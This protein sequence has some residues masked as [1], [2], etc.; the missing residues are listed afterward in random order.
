MKDFNVNYQVKGGLFCKIKTRVSYY[1][2]FHA[3]QKVLKDHF[4][5]QNVHAICLVEIVLKKRIFA[6]EAKLF[7]SWK[8]WAIYHID[9]KS[10]N[11][12]YNKCY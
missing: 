8:V 3:D 7:F 5:M 1:Y 6:V 10:K 9:G 4:T 11:Y 2:N 12:Y